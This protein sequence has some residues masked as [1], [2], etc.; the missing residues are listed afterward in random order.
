MCACGGWVWCEGGFGVR[1]ECGFGLLYCTAV[2]ILLHISVV[3]VIVSHTIPPHSLHQRPQRPL[4]SPNLKDTFTFWKIK[5][6][7]DDRFLVSWVG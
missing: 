1:V 6:K 7:I 5:I 4:L 2:V 3:S